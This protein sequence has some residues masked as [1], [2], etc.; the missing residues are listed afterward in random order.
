MNNNKPSRNL[1]ID[2]FSDVL[3]IWAYG[4][5]I[6]IDQLKEEFGERIELRYRFIPLFGATNKRIGEGWSDR[7]GY[8]GF[9][10]HCLDIA[11]SWD[12]VTVH[13]DIWC[14]CRPSSSVLIHLF[15]KAVELSANDSQ[16][17][18]FEKA[19]WLARDAFFKHAINICDPAAL[20]NIT[21]KLEL[22][23]GQ[24]KSLMDNGEAYAALHQDHEAQ[25]EH[26]IPGSPTLIMNNGR[27]QLYGNLG[28]RV[29]K[30]NVEE[31][32]RD[33]RSGEAS[34]C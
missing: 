4:A 21:T 12:H 1:V 7:G 18:T 8:D 14:K 28:Y 34:W 29:L 2:Y 26:Q 22:P 24:I 17:N 6:R 11:K 9:N 30:A 3:C 32:L 20:K 25:K 5:Q 15:L 31:L 13:P 33:P 23:F 19:I 27:Q 16:N 10:K